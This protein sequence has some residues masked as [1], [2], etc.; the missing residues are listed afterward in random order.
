MMEIPEADFPEGFEVSKDEERKP[1]WGGWATAGF[2]LVVLIVSLIV[3][4]IVIVVFLM[5]T[6]FSEGLVDLPQVMESIN[7]KMGLIVSITSIPGAIVS[8]ALIIGFIKLRKGAR[9]KEYLGLNPT[10]KKTVLAVLAISIGFII[11]SEG[12]GLILEPPTSEFGIEMY[13]TSVWPPLLWVAVILF[14]PAFEEVLFRGFLFEGFRQSRIGAIG[15]IGLTAFIWTLLHVQYGAFEITTIFV[16][17]IIMGIVRFKTGS[18]WSVL[19]MHGFHNM[20]VTIL[21]ALYVNGVI[22]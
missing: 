14:A 6:L 21:T 20:V 1:V 13:R 19:I 17:G 18:L 10:S 9:I 2:G 12:L 3:Q 8:V 7:D 22:S 4:I 5:A 15:A 16:L 11:F